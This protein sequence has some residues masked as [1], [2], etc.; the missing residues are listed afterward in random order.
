[1]ADMQAIAEAAFQQLLKEELFIFL[2]QYLDA[3]EI[4]ALEMTLY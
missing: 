2:P 3:E 1:M 4:E